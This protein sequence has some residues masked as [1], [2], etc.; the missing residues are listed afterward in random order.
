MSLEARGFPVRAVL[1]WHFLMSYGP[2]GTSAFQQRRELDPI[3]QVRGEALLRILHHRK[4]GQD[5]E[6]L[7][8]VLAAHCRPGKKRALVGEWDG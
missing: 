8:L 7:L 4:P 3:V 1:L 6:S 5:P 2:L